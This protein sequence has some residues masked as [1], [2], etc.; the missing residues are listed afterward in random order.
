M[1][2]SHVNEICAPG[3]RPDPRARRREWR[4][5]YAWRPVLVG[6][7]DCRWLEWVECRDWFLADVIGPTLA[8]GYFT[9]E[10]RAPQ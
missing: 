4:P 8:A 3:P 2:Y 5:W 1:N 10:Y 6:Q 7:R 9:R